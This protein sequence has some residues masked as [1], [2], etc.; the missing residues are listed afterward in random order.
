[1]V[2]VEIKDMKA[3]F[4]PSVEVHWKFYYDGDKGP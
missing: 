1:M 4:S 3:V 2:L